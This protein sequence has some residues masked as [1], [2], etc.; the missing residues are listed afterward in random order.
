MNKEE[1]IARAKELFQAGY[2]LDQIRAEIGGEASDANGTYR[3]RSYK[4]Q[5]VM[6]N[7]KTLQ[8]G[9]EKRKRMQIQQSL[10]TGETE[11]PRGTT[12]K[13]KRAELGATSPD[14]EL[15]HRNSLIGL[16]PFYD[17]L[18]DKDARKLTDWVRET[19]WSIGDLDANT[20]IPAQMK[21]HRAIH[22]WLRT[23]G[24]EGATI[25]KRMKSNMAGLSLDQRKDAMRYYF[26]YVQSGADEAMDTIIGPQS[27]SPKHDA[28]QAANRAELQAR[29]IPS[30]P[31]AGQRLPNN[32]RTIGD[33]IIR[34]LQAG[35]AKVNM[36]AGANAGLRRAALMAPI[37]GASLF[38][39]QQEVQAREQAYK[40]DPTPL[41]GFQRDLSKLAM[42][43][44]AAALTPAAVVAEPASVLANMTNMAI[45]NRSKIKAAAVN[46]KKG[47]DFFRDE[48]VGGPGN[49]LKM[50][51]QIGQQ[52]WN[53]R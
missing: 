17:G 46:T 27:R 43:A 20:D 10:G 9:A 7:V 31:R 18:N 24:L 47:A 39:S 26:E 8:A 21:D 13:S 25:N 1:Y 15:H 3:L 22:R 50:G 44:D 35:A 45:D 6:K 30:G 5:L 19:G 40:D 49:L 34:E 23:Q 33:R 16:E 11:M 53:N 38:F 37:G 42:G 48:I 14:I 2:S 52:W 32:R 41:K 36:P 51:L 12:D 4:D 28:A 29:E